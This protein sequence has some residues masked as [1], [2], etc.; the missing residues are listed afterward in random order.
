M[1]PLP[2]ALFRG[3]PAR[4]HCVLP[5]PHFSTFFSFLLFTSLHFTSL[6]LT[7][8]HSTSLHFTP[9]ST[10]AVRPHL[11][12]A[13]DVNSVR[14]GALRCA[15]VAEGAP[16]G[17]RSALPMRATSVASCYH[18]RITTFREQ[19]RGV[20]MCDSSRLWV[21][22]RFRGRSLPKNDPC[23]VLLGR[24]GRGESAHPTHI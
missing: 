11:Q 21:P 6:H 23:A 7:P 15:A 13:W 5:W 9:L 4:N 20:V 1:L 19:V 8:L 24:V 3:R 22:G 2:R 12:L 14:G 17:V 18:H 16:S 10:T